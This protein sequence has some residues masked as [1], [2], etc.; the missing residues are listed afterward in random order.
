MAQAAS[1]V[2]AGIVG[3]PRAVVRRGPMWPWL[4]V[5]P[6]TFPTKAASMSFGVRPAAWMASRETFAAASRAA[7]SMT[8]KRFWETPTMQG[9]GMGIAPDYRPSAIKG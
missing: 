1:M 7:S 2:R 5:S 6:N 3:M 4:S 8:P 9:W